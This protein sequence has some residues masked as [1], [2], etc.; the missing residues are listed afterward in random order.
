MVSCF[1]TKVRLQ[2]L[3]QSLRGC[4]EEWLERL[5][6]NYI[7]IVKNCRFIFCSFLLVFLVF[8]FLFCCCYTLSCWT[9]R[10]VCLPRR[11]FDV[12]VI[13]AF[14]HSFLQRFEFEHRNHHSLMRSAFINSACSRII[15]LFILI[16]N[17]PV[18][19]FE[20]CKRHLVRK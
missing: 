5:L 10:F 1:E 15:S 6:K 3:G 2:R 16:F 11:L 20:Y 14:K 9:P 4:D 8:L 18:T 17:N 13:L 19:T 7:V 12:I